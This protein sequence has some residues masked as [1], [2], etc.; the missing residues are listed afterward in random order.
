MT[1]GAAAVA[2][3]AVVEAAAVAVT[4]AVEDVLE[5]GSAQT[6]SEDCTPCTHM[7]AGSAGPASS[8]TVR[9]LCSSRTHR[10]SCQLLQHQLG[11][12]YQVQQVPDK[13]VLCCKPPSLL[14][15]PSPLTQPEIS[16]AVF[17]FGFSVSPVPG[18]PRESELTRGDDM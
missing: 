2:A 14:P 13:C 18:C 5:T 17:F 9:A 3:A 10:S 12:A 4:A 6:W 11:H 15:H 7:L 1:Q 16:L 8:Q